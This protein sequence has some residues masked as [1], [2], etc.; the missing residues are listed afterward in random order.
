MTA[1]LAPSDRGDALCGVSTRSLCAGYLDRTI[2]QGISLSLPAGRV[3]VIVGP[4][5]SGKTTLIKALVGAP[6]PESFWW[7]GEIELPAGER[8]VQWQMPM[9]PSRTLGSILCRSETDPRLVVERARQTL[10][11]T[12]R[13]DS[14]VYHWLEPHIDTPIGELCASRYRLAALT[15]VLCQRSAGLYI[16]DE[17]DAELPGEAMTSLGACLASLGRVATVLLVTHHLHLARQVSD[18]AV[19]MVD[20]ELV[21]A[22]E[23]RLFFSHPARQRTRDFLR[24]GS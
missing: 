17:P 11:A 23:S 13:S 22:A 1:R 2:L 19:L 10:G 14:F 15:R 18:Y 4:G 16:F 3:S 21:E 5:G 7:S 24:T 20:G 12:W 9:D 6:F 8:C